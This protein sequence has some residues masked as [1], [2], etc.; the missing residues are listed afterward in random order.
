MENL[1]LSWSRI[2]DT[3]RKNSFSN[4]KL[5]RYKWLSLA[6][7]SADDKLFDFI[8]DLIKKYPKFIIRGCSTDV[9]QELSTLGFKAV[10]AGK[11]A[12]LA[13]PVANKKKSLSELVKRGNSSGTFNERY[14]SPAIKIKLEELEKNA[15]HAQK[16]KLEKLFQQYS[17]GQRL[18]VIENENQ[19]LGA[20]SISKINNRKYQIEQ[21]FKRSTA[22]NGVMESLIIQ[23]AELLETEGINNFSLGEVPFVIPPKETSYKSKIIKLS[24]SVFNYAYNYKTLYYFKNKF[25]PTWQDIY[26]CGFPDIPLTAIADISI[27]SK[28]LKLVY[29]EALN[30]FKINKTCSQKDK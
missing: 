19:W 11:E 9:K 1:P 29:R 22:P 6:Q 30:Y 8:Q 28:Y 21:M 14:F 18:F 2:I 24:G 7:L 4:L 27:K 16:I 25:K 12:C 23:T 13:L 17:S 5:S 10:L 26:I 3:R 20:I 15:R